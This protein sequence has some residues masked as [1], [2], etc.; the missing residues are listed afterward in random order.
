MIHTPAQPDNREIYCLSL[1]FMDPKGT[2]WAMRKCFHSKFKLQE[3]TLLK[4]R[5]ICLK[6]IGTNETLSYATKI[7]RKIKPNKKDIMEKIIRDTMNLEIED[8]LKM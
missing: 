2:E 7:C 3:K 4:D 1:E 8:T 6:N 5:L